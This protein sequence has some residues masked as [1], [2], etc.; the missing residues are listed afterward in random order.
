[1]LCDPPV[2]PG[3]VRLREALADLPGNATLVAVTATVWLVRIGFGA[4]YFPS[5]EM[6][7]ITGLIDHV[8]DWSGLFSTVAVNCCEPPGP[9][10]GRA[11]L[12]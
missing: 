6:L 8:T 1:M 5:A 7:P 10:T 2:L 3:G 9:S 11:D 12:S 4:K